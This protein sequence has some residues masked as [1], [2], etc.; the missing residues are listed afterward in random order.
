MT[1][2]KQRDA[3]WIHAFG[4]DDEV[5]RF[6]A[7]GE[8]DEVLRFHARGDDDEILRFHAFGEDREDYS[9][10]VTVTKR[11]DAPWVHACGEDDGFFTLHI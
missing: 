1:V 8:D 2:T 5:L 4:E 3:P 11:R 6:H 10:N 9:C 7:R